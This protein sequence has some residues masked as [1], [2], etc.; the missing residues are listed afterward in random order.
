MHPE[1]ESVI[2][3]A[4]LLGLDSCTPDLTQPSAVQWLLFPP[5]AVPSVR[6][7]N[8]ERGEKR[9]ESGEKGDAFTSLLGPGCFEELLKERVGIEAS[10]D[11]HLNRS[12]PPPL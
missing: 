12:L 8:E 4:S 1:L 5:Y 2:T 9:K 10:V 11:E 3:S 7:R 6:E